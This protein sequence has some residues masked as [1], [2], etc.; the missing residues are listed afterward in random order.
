MMLLFRSRG[1]R[2]EG[3]YTFQIFLEKEQIGQIPSVQQLLDTSCLSGDL[4]FEEVST[5]SSF[6]EQPQCVY[7]VFVFTIT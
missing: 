4:K 5:C 1:E 2:S 7:Q 3:A 6:R